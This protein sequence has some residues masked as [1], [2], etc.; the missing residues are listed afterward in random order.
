MQNM[1]YIKKYTI[2]TQKEKMRVK[3]QERA[4][5]SSMHSILLMGFF[6]PTTRTIPP[7]RAR[8]C[9]KVI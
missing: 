6:T 2:A 4:D 9:Y 7:Q 3:L 8:Y 1:I 5:A